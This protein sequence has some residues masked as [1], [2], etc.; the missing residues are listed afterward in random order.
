LTSQK[1]NLQIQKL[2]VTVAVVLFIIKIVAYFL[3]QSVA[4]LTDALESTVNVI[5]GFIGLFSLYV[6]AKPQDEDHPYGHGK[7]E[8]VS[9]AVEGTL[10]LVAGLII[11]YESIDNFIHPH[12]IQKLDYGII[13]VAVTAI[14]NFFVGYISIR[15]GKRNNSLA[16]S[17]SGR[18]LQTDTYS[19]LGI[20]VGLLLILMTGYKWLD[21]VIAIIFA[22]IIMFTGYRI[23]RSSLAG[24]MDEIDKDLLSK[25]VVTLNNNRRENWIDLH[26]LR[27][28]KYGGQ[29]HIDCHMT[30]P[31]YLNVNEA[32][33]E[34][35]ALIALIKKEF[36]DSIEFFV[37][38]DGCL[39][40]Q[41][42]LCNKQDCQVRQYPFG[43]RITWTLDNI[44]SNKKHQQ[45]AATGAM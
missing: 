7:A 23:I 5:A 44:V 6:A 31:W 9:A 3:T 41:C 17:A 32:H 20:I 37:H 24:I 12:T 34:I 16:L 4:I 33:K 28:I 40:T 15:K 38:T 19:T 2:V 8:F 13:L 42:S 21:G 14:I 43:K 35:D 11:V 45:P 39:Y 18:H 29:L 1:E 27:V 10:I 30:V 25:L 36:G 26:N 22:F